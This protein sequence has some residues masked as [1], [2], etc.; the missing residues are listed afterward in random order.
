MRL[1]VGTG[2]RGRAREKETEMGG[3]LMLKWMAGAV[4]ELN[5]NRVSRV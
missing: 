2:A 3:M 5:R 4:A 1:E